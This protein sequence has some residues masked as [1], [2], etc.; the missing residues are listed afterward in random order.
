MGWTW[1][2]DKELLSLLCLLFV[3]DSLGAPTT[4]QILYKSKGFDALRKKECT[5]AGRK[6]Q[7]CKKDVDLHQNLHFYL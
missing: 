3:T 4:M 7:N 1:I 2:S 5:K 6:E